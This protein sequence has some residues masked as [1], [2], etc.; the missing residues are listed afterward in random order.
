MVHSFHRT[1]TYGRTPTHDNRTT[2]FCCTSH[3]NHR[4]ESEACRSK[5]LT[6]KHAVE[7]RFEMLYP[8][9]FWAEHFGH[10]CRNEWTKS[11]I[12]RTKSIRLKSIDRNLSTSKSKA[13]REC[14]WAEKYPQHADHNQQLLQKWCGTWSTFGRRNNSAHRR[15]R[16]TVARVCHIPVSWG[17]DRNH[18]YS[19]YEPPP[20]WYLERLGVQT[21][22]IHSIVKSKKYIGVP[23]QVFTCCMYMDQLDVFLQNECTQCGQYR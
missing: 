22:E 14:K 9:K 16:G 23:P 1:W 5:S 8:E 19:T 11:W 21:S 6:E 12:L 13:F 18:N 17:T 4:I 3:H 7:T 2:T 10:M 20:L 15:G